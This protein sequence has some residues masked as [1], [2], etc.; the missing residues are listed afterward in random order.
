MSGKLTP[1]SDQ[2]MPASSDLTYPKDGMRERIRSFL[3]MGIVTALACYLPFHFGLYALWSAKSL[4]GHAEGMVVIATERGMSFPFPGV[5]N[6]CDMIYMFGVEGEVYDGP[7][8][9]IHSFPG[10]CPEVRSAINVAY[11]TAHPTQNVWGAEH[12]SVVLITL[13]GITALGCL[14]FLLQSQFTWH[15]QC[16][17]RRQQWHDDQERKRK[18]AVL[19]N[20]HVDSGDMSLR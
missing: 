4:D 6:W 10:R 9:P 15:R 19:V 14:Y 16:E 11:S 12:N 7:S 8:A 18:M 1:G 2:E 3:I 17:I 20:H 5:T 13:S